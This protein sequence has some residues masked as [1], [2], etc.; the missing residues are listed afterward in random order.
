LKTNFSHPTATLFLSIALHGLLVG[1]ILLCTRPQ[2]LVPGSGIVDIVMTELVHSSNSNEVK[3]HP[4]T[5]QFHKKVRR[6]ETS[7][8]ESTQSSVSP[9][10]AKGPGVKLD[11]WPKVLHEQKVD[12][13][14]QAKMNG[15][16][17]TVVLRI[18]INEEGSPAEVEIVS[19]PGE[20]LN[21]AAASALRG[22]QF[23]PAY[24]NKKPVAVTILYNYKFRI[25]GQ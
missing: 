14:A 24:L 10:D 25:S 15:L 22:F 7:P 11:R 17:G 12:Y 9:S 13:P 1:V 4:E 3:S 20:G 5:S 21:E 23:S 6:Q 2:A 8:N 16:Q 19:G 18:T